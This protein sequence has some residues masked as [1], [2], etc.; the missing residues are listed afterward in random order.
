MT[1]LQRTVL[2]VLILLCCHVMPAAAQE[3]AGEVLQQMERGDTAPK[4]LPAPPKLDGLP[5]KELEKPR[6]VTP[7]DNTRLF[8]KQITVDGRGM[9]ESTEISAITAPL[10]RKHHALAALVTVADR[11]TTL[12]RAHGYLSS[13]AYIPPQELKDGVLT[14]KIIAGVPGVITVNGNQSYSSD[15]IRGHL[16]KLKGS[17]PL[18]EADLMRQ[19]LILNEYD[20]LQARAALKAG[21]EPGSTDI[22]VSVTDKRPFHAALSYDNFGSHSIS[23]SRLSGHI[24]AGNLAFNGDLLTLSGMTGLNTIDIDRLS[25]GRAEYRTAINHSGT[26]LGAYYANNLYQAGGNIAGLDLNGRANVAGLYLSHPL[27][28]KAADS[29]TFKLGFEY[30]DVSDYL[31]GGLNS[32][33]KIRTLQTELY[34]DSADHWGG[35][36]ILSAAWVMGLKGVLGGAEGRDSKS[37]RMN[38]TGDFNRLT[39]DAARYQSLG[40]RHQLVLKAGGQYSPDELFVAEQ[41][42]LGGAYSIRGYRPSFRS[43]DSGYTLGAELHLA[44]T[45]AAPNTGE[46]IP[47]LGSAS[48]YL[49]PFVDQ[50]GVYRNNPQPGEAASADLTSAGAGL[51]LYWG[52]VSARLDCAVPQSG[53]WMIKNAQTWLQ[54]AVS[55]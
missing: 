8:I 1:G 44:L 35:R 46:L 49:V 13:Y 47:P 18:N 32:R 48:L 23:R 14:V 28:R 27:I 29:L 34:H 31:L 33:D 36:N 7:E 16:E 25:Y 5:K 54:V 17:G 19:L 42:F 2:G 38:A 3:R 50:G 24:G 26:R 30:K 9:L 21:K 4:P 55:F 15:F 40:G 41:Y 53:G 37:S 22:Q 20:S 52:K 39:F 6:V 12:L 45:N 51:R 10:E 43:G 11:L